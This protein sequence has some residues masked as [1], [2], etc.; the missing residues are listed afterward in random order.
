MLYNTW[1]KL[2]TSAVVQRHLQDQE[3]DMGALAAFY[4][5]WQVFG[6]KTLTCDYPQGVYWFW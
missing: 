2:G 6:N 5:Q 1:E 3:K 4:S